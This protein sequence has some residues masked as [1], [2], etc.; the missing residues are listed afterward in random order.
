MP[1]ISVAG[2]EAAPAAASCK[3]IAGTPLATDSLHLHKGVPTGGWV[4]K[5]HRL[6]R[7][8]REAGLSREAI[9]AA[10]P[11]WWED[12]L[13]D[14]PSGE[15]ELRFALSRR[16]GLSPRALI[17]ERVE[18]VWNDDAFFKRLAAKDEGQR[19][20]LTSFGMALGRLVLRGAPEG[21]GLEG[22]AAKGLR[23]AILASRPT[24]DL[25]GLLATCWGLGVPVLQLTVF[26]LAAKSMHAMVVGHDG[27]HAILLA[28][29]PRYPAQ[30]AFTLAH[31][32]AHAALGHLG[33]APAI[34][35]M[36]DPAQGGE[37][38]DQEEEADRFALE[39]L[40]GSPQPDIRIEARRFSAASLARAVAVTAPEHG[41]EPGSL[42]L[43][44]GHARGAW[45]TAMKALA[46]L[47]PDPLDV[48]WEIN[49]VARAQLNW[50]AIGS[51]GTDWL[52]KILGP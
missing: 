24:V 40:T 39:I 18:F 41:I 3:V 11:S 28:R 22:L 8:L 38:D 47:N 42:A 35:D 50:D 9:D 44:V 4:A 6:R 21:P 31:E 12:T 52:D 10:W 48:G 43:C 33:A 20:A 17:G 46:I 49:R 34:V 7:E 1:A 30:A 51:D 36:G 5:E 29:A 37:A 13:Q 14:E 32:M 16:L 27:R 26:P 25:G 23:A 19:A 15:A 45:Q 2:V